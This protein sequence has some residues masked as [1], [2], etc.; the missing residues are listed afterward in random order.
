MNRGRIGNMRKVACVIFG[1][2]MCCTTLAVFGQQGSA[3]GVLIDLGTLGGV[4]SGAYDINGLGQVVGQTVDG[5]GNG[6]GFVINPIDVDGDGDLE[7]FADE[8]PA[9]G[10]ND[11]M[12]PL[13]TLGSTSPYATNAQAINSMK[14]QVT[15]WSQAAGDVASRAFLLTPEDS[16]GDGVPDTWNK[17]LDGDNANDLM[18]NLGTL[19]G[20]FSCGYDVNN[21]GMVVGSSDTGALYPSSDS[22]AFLWRPTTFQ[23]EHLLEAGWGFDGICDA[24]PI[25]GYGG[26]W[27]EYMVLH[28][29]D[30]LDETVI[31]LVGFDTSG[32]IYPQQLFTTNPVIP[33]AKAADVADGKA[34][35]NLGFEPTGKPSYVTWVDMS[36]HDFWG[37]GGA[38]YIEGTSRMCDDTLV[39]CQHLADD[40]AIAIYKLAFADMYPGE[41]C[42]EFISTAIYPPVPGSVDGRLP[43][44]CSVDIGN[45]YVVWK[46]PIDDQCDIYAFDLSSY[47]EPWWGRT[48]GGVIRVTSTPETIEDEPTTDGAWIAWQAQDIGATSTRIE[49]YNMDTGEFRTVAS[50]GAGNYRPSISGDLIAYDSDVAGNLDVWLCRIWDG[51]HWQITTDPTDQ[52]AND[53]FDNFIAYSDDYD[54]V[55]GY[56]SIRVD[57][58]AVPEG[59]SSD[60][61][62][63]IDL[64]T[65]GGEESFALAINDWG[66]VG[67][68]SYT[69]S[70][71]IHAFMIEPL[72]LD[73]DGVP[74][75]WNR[76]LNGDGAN[77]LM[78]DLSPDLV[79]YGSAVCDV[80]NAKQ[81]VGSYG[82]YAV[83]W[84]NG[85]GMTYLPTLGGLAGAA[86]ANNDAGN[87][88]GISATG[89]SGEWHAFFYDGSRIIDMGFDG[90][91]Q[92]VNDLDQVVGWSRPTGVPES[93]GWIWLAH[94]T[95]SPPDDMI[96]DLEDDIG[97]LAPPGPGQ[98]PAPGEPPPPLTWG[99]ANSLNHKLDA[100]IHQWLVRGNVK[101]A[102][103][104]LGAF[105]NEVESL[106]SEGVLTEAQGILLISQA[107][108]IAAAIQPP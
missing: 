53:V 25:L 19:G 6:V 20:D 28:E 89:E 40:L 55:A 15:G 78:R 37:W 16:D 31:R 71:K 107:N 66:N 83:K 11:L 82:I 8:N 102:T 57:A 60:W 64:G 12:T 74:E 14:S 79:G 95:P 87:I 47:T 65:L 46:Q 39:W 32:G 54:P 106:V 59:S 108:A 10:A 18:R 41:Y 51:S 56:T 48:H 7:W 33:V 30:Y 75:V 99:Q 97:D 81:A 38:G 22:H 63:M 62:G 70:G 52:Y 68:V 85:N 93:R 58:F 34:M 26:S 42:P 1:I 90:Y 23:V 21:L 36:T 44:P 5:V 3:Q 77:D 86:V 103:N 67:G 80:N 105:V 50:N 88:V 69:A 43:S 2:A 49:A 104:I 72:D 91:P 84:E 76:D 4:F 101:A 94:E 35:Y 96:D 17:D 24:S 92:A 13:G 73:G 100:V 27:S 45:R 29:V 9:D 61:G 98:P